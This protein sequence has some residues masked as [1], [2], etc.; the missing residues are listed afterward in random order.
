M[1]EL[2]SVT[3]VLRSFDEARTRAFYCGFLGFDLL[4]EHRFEPDLPLYMI[5]AREGCVLH[6]SEHYGDATPGSAIRVAVDDVA[7]YARQLREKRFEN[8]RPGAP[9]ETEWHS[10]EMTI[11]DPAGNRLIFHSDLPEARA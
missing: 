4:F 6:L 11:I 2:G 7:A 8:A 5:M 1:V 3:P 10:L 9:V